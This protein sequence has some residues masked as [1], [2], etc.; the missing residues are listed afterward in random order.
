MEKILKPSWLNYGKSYFWS[1]ICLFLIF[2]F[3]IKYLYT[4]EILNPFLMFLILVLIFN[5]ILQRKCRD[6][7]IT[8]KT[9]SSFTGIFSRTEDEI[10]IKDIREIKIHQNLIQ[11]TFGLGDILFASAATGSMEIKFEGIKNPKEIK[12]Q[13]NEIQQ[14]IYS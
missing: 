9:I 3:R 7:V 11:R 5:S 10:N 2:L 1:I 12:K 14:S 8:D 6:Y 4:L 13:I